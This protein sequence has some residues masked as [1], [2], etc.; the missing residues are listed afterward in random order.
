MELGFDNHR[1]PHFYAGPQRF[2]KIRPRTRER[3]GVYEDKIVMADRG[4]IKF[5]FGIGTVRRPVPKF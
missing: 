4:G 1:L 2:G 3:V 5:D